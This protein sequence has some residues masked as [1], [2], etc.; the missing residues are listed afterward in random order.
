[1][2]P[3]PHV[4]Q[5]ARPVNPERQISRPA[6]NQSPAKA[7]VQAPQ[8]RIEQRVQQRQ[9]PLQERVQ[10]RQEERELRA[11]PPQQRAQRREEIQRQRVQQNQQNVQ[12]PQAQAQT[13]A[14]SLQR[15]NGNARV[16]TQAARQGRFA[17]QAQAA[18]A[19]NARN[20]AG[21]FAA[22]HAWARGQRA[23]FVP[24]LGRVFWP[25]AYSDIFDYAFWP[26]AYDDGYWAYAYDEMFDGVF[27]A[28]GG[29]YSN[30]ANAAPN[31]T[32]G[33]A[34]ANRDV[35][36]L[37]GDPGQGITAWPFAEIQQAVQP[38]AEQKI[39]LG[40]VK[41]AAAKAASAFKT[42]CTSAAPMTPS[43]R[44]QAM[45]KR[46]EATLE[47]VLTVR[48][49]LDKFYNSLSD[50]QKARFNAIGPDI[51][52][53]QA[54]RDARKRTEADNA[55]ACGEAKPGLVNLPIEQIEDAVKPS[56]DQQGALDRLE[57]ANKQAADTLQTACPEE[58][59]LTPAGRLEA[60][61]KRLQ[62]MVEAA[63]T[64]QP[65]L[66]EFYAVLNNE[67]KAR[68]NTMTAARS[69]G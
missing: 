33:S 9:N 57:Q 32:T 30:Y 5:P 13:Q 21:R 47:A 39:L 56:D 1:M 64:L 50:E 23:A 19:P 53:R 17:V 26:D 44:L 20:R 18:A 58:T 69:N 14:R 60:T 27:W 41:E 61:E 34:Q 16:S 38:N 45:T 4:A 29:P 22:R 31:E 36:A 7:A 12:S 51:R 6:A 66:D 54:D 49:A 65:A 35:A 10:R 42:S 62:A 67:Q 68:F 63:K 43:G 2:R 28:D 48:P 24:W 8:N 37:C 3:A 25:Y 59:P 55:K 15:R 11:L 46:L 40:D 52:Q